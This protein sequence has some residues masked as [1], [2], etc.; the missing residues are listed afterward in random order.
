MESEK[1]DY[2]LLYWSG[3]FAGRGE[4]IRM[5]LHL[6]GVKWEDTCTEKGGNPMNLANA[7]KPEFPILFPPI[8]HEVKTNF[9]MN[10]TNNIL[11]YLGEK[12]G[13]AG[14]NSHERAYCMQ[15]AMIVNDIVAESIV[16]YHPVETHAS[17]AS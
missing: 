12:Y 5:L 3:G 14:A 11:M 15:I 10:G 7:C 17:Y 13:L 6:A 1:L 4:P 8:L 16:A 2:R 9:V